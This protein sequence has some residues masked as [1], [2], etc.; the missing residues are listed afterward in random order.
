MDKL[1]GVLIVLSGLLVCFGVVSL[2]ITWLAPGIAG[3]RFFRRMLVGSRIPP[4]R[5]NKTLMAL[6][7][8]VLGAYV[9]LSR[10]GY[11]MAGYVAVALWLPLAFLVMRSA[12]PQHR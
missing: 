7:L 9:L 1:G 5:S 11:D 6:W 8:A 3:T 10:G 4:T 12:R 2:A